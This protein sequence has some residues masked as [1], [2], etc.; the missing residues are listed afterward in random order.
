[1]GTCLGMPFIPRPPKEGKFVPKA[2]VTA[3]AAVKVA[4]AFA[5][6][7]DELFDDA[8]ASMQKLPTP[9]HGNNH[10]TLTRQ[11]TTS[12]NG[13]SPEKKG[14]TRHHK[15]A[16]VAEA[17]TQTPE[18]QWNIWVDNP[19]AESKQTACGSSI[20]SFSTFSTVQD[21]YNNIHHPSNLALRAD[22]NCFKNKIEPKWEDPAN[23]GAWTMTF[24]R[25]ESDNC[26]LSTEDAKKLNRNA[27]NRYTI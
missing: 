16:A 5:V 25:W 7:F 18:P 10:E 24:R 26:W 12:K 22:C 21:L 27:K 3:V 4:P 20:P 6:P 1:G 9:E 15:K 8:E 14:K 11:K 19:S 23:G 13:R 17:I 2:V